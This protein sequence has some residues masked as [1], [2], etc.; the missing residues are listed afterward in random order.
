MG[1]GS[2]DVRFG[3]IEFS[4]SPVGISQLSNSKSL[5]FKT[6]EKIVY[7]KKNIWTLFTEKLIGKKCNKK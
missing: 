3:F 1:G 4:E 2:F 7:F 6:I 5:K